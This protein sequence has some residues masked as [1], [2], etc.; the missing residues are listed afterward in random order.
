MHS[1]TVCL[2]DKVKVIDMVEEKPVVYYTIQF[3]YLLLACRMFD[4]NKYLH[5]WWEM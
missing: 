3:V 1:A 5:G 4:A 2:F